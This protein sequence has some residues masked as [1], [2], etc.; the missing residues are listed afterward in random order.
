[1]SSIRQFLILVITSA[2]LVACGSKTDN[3]NS[4]ASAKDSIPVFEPNWESI[5]KNYKDLEWFN[6][7]QFGIFI[8]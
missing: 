4:V 7:K 1:M 3:K 2:L 6:D 5:K 8:H